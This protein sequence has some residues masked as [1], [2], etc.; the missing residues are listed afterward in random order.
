MS[1]ST[2]LQSP[3]LIAP[4]TWVIPQIEAA[5]PDRFVSINSMVITATEPVIVDTGCAINR[6]QW[7]ADTFAIV[8]PADVRWIFLSHGDRDHVGNLAA[9]LEACP[10]ATAITTM[11]GLRYL[12]ADGAPPLERVRWVNDGESFDAGDRTLAAVRPPMWDATSTRGLLDVKTGVYWAA[13]SFASMF[14]HPVTDASQLDHEFWRCSFIE[15][16]RS[17]CE[18]LTVIDPSKFEARIANTERLARMVASAHGPTLSGAM[19]PEAYRLLHE[20]ASMQPLP[21]P[22]QTVLDQMVGQLVAA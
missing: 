19:V 11:W 8:E 7:L 14:T 4:E 16:H 9:L 18:W 12:L 10:Q 1:G 17:Y 15:E 6:E 3:Y 5:G 13:D 22:G 20:I 2:R 21:A